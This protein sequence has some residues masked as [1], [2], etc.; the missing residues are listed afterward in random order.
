VALVAFAAVALVAMPGRAAGHAE[1]LS[2][3]PPANA[4]LLDA[5]ERLTLTFSEAVDP[6]S[7]SVRLLDTRQVAVPGTGDAL[8]AEDEAT[9]TVSLPGLE[10]GVYTVDYR[11]TSAVDGHIT[12]GIFAFLVDPTGTEP[13]PGV[14]SETDSPNATPEGTATR[15]LALA[16]VLAMAGI[17]SFWLLSARP[18]MGRTGFSASLPWGAVSLAGLLAFAGLV[19]HLLLSARPLLEAGDGGT[20]WFPLDPAAPFGTTQFAV[21]MRVALLGTLAA[22]LCAAIARRFARREGAWAALTLAAAAVGLAG[23]SF[24]GHA[25]ASGGP[26]NT[27]LDLLHLAAV[28]TW[29]G[30][31]VGLGLLALRARAAAGI[32]LHRHSRVSLVAAPAVVLTG[33]ANSPVVLGNEARDLVSSEY[34]NLLLAKV[35]L[36]AVAVGLGAVNFFLVRRHRIRAV[37]PVIAA[38]L[39]VGTLAVVAAAGLV[40]GQP[41]AG[42]APVLTSSAIGAAH[43][44]GTAGESAVHA[45]VNLPA[46]GPQRYQVSVTDPETGEYRT[47]VQRV[48]LV[49]Q[50]PD[51][52]GLADERVQLEESAEPGLWGAGGAFTPVVGDWQLQ[53]IVRRVGELDEVASFPLP[54]TTPLRPQRIPPPDTGIGVPIP[55]ALL[56]E[57]LPRG[58]AGWLIAAALLAAAAA[59][60]AVGRGSTG[61]TLRMGRALIVASAVL[62]G[63]GAGSRA[64]VDAANAPPASAARQANPVPATDVSISRG[65]ALYLANCSSCHGA[66]GAGDGPI[67]A[68]MLPSPPALAEPIGEMSD[69]AIAYRIAVGSAGTRMPAF[70]PTLTEN[71]RWD[72][73]NFL[74]HRFGPGP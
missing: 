61:G 38:E 35:L 29:L 2:S 16:A 53:V 17:L 24:A 46:P 4:T 39:V 10:P 9:V 47:D 66:E 34:G 56:W 73:V 13:A 8:V 55:L 48:F 22:T 45:A 69:G 28:A 41:A 15:W 14:S 18:A 50:P 71:D 12:S 5:P 70:A 72:L 30:G 11:V 19:A 33:I 44:Y 7:A 68:G 52:S 64:L 20:G 42:R 3:D 65:R 21:A 57:A 62:I 51:G 27:A 58:R 43:L 36:F 74:R 31:L 23:M 32:A 6:G 1:L 26:L 49:F 54:V 37:L 60:F 67:A 59:L 40:T 25:A 63:L